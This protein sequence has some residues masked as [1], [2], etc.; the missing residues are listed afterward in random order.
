MQRSIFSLFTF[1]V[2]IILLVSCSADEDPIVLPPPFVGGTIDAEVGGEEQ[3][4]QVYID[5]SSNSTTVIQR[6]SWDLGFSNAGEFRVILNSSNAMLAYKLE[7]TDF[8]QV[9]PA[10]TIGLGA[11]LSLSAIFG[12]LFSTV[13]P[14]WLSETS[15][16]IDY[17]TRDL[18]RTALGE[19]SEDPTQNFVFVINRGRNIDN[20]D[21]DWKKVLISRDASSYRIRYS[22]INGGNENE[23]S[24]EKAGNFNFSF[25]NFDQGLVQVEPQADSWDLAFTTWTEL[26]GFGTDSIPYFFKDY[27]I[28]NSFGVEASEV[29]IDSG[30]VLI[31]K[32]NDFS[33]E[34]ALGINY[35]SRVNFI[36]GGWRTVASPTPGSVTG[37]RNDRFYVIKDPAGN[38]YKLLFTKMLN[39]SGQRGFPQILFDLL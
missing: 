2:S 1:L 3:P 25:L 35:T 15:T 23:M 5:L 27:V 39:N 11:K 13:T 16:W 32:F 26:E 31:E 29:L 20:S 9:S 10:D 8:D 17:P 12:A 34:D 7:K 30:A 38:Y 28:L 14:P 33:S 19:I 24:I 4:N 18:T 21:K 6:D 22:D 37:V 36:G